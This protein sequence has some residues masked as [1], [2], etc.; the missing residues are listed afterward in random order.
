M[1]TDTTTS[2]TT[3]SAI[4]TTMRLHNRDAGILDPA[5]PASPSS[6]TSVVYSPG[7]SGG[8]S[9]VSVENMGYPTGS[10]ARSRPK[11]PTMEQHGATLSP[12]RLQRPDGSPGGGP[13]GG[14]GDVQEDL[15]RDLN[16][17]GS[18]DFISKYS[19]RKRA[20]GTTSP[21]GSSRAMSPTHPGGERG[22][23]G[24]R[25]IESLRLKLVKVKESQ[26]R[27]ER[28]GRELEKRQTPRRREGVVRGPSFGPLKDQRD[29]SNS[30]ESLSTSSRNSP[31]RD[32][33]HGIPAGGLS[34]GDSLASSRVQTTTSVPM[35]PS[36]VADQ[37]HQRAWSEPNFHS[38]RPTDDE[39]DDDSE[40]NI[41][42]IQRKS[43]D[44]VGGGIQEVDNNNKAQSMSMSNSQTHHGVTSTAQPSS[45]KT[46]T[47]CTPTSSPEGDS[48]EESTLS[49]TQ[50]KNSSSSTLKD[51]FE[52]EEDLSPRCQMSSAQ[53]FEK[54]LEEM[55]LLGSSHKRRPPAISTK[56]SDV[57]HQH[58]IRTVSDPANTNVTN[59]GFTTHPLTPKSKR[60]E[61]CHLTSPDETREQSHRK[62]TDLLAQLHSETSRSLPG[63]GVERKEGRRRVK[64][65][66]GVEGEEDEGVGHEESDSEERPGQTHIPTTM[67]SMSLAEAPLGRGTDDSDDSSGCGGVGRGGRAGNG[68][69]PVGV[70]SGKLANGRYQTHPTGTERTTGRDLSFRSMDSNGLPSLH[71]ASSSSSETA[72]PAPE[73]P[74]SQVSSGSVDSHIG[75]AEDAMGSTAEMSTYPDVV[76][77][78]MAEG[79]DVSDKFERRNGKSLKQK[80]K[81]DPSGDKRKVLQ[82]SQD[83][84]STIEGSHAQSASE[85]DRCEQRESLRSTPSKLCSKQL[86]D[87]KSKSEQLLCTRGR[88]TGA[89]LSKPDWSRPFLFKKSPNK[90]DSSGNKIHSQHSS[91]D[92]PTRR[93]SSTDS[94][95]LTDSQTESNTA[96]SSPQTQSPTSTLDRL[97]VGR[98]LDRSVSSASALAGGRGSV[99]QRPRDLGGRPKTRP[100]IQDVFLGGVYRPPS[101]A[102]L[103]PPRGR[104]GG[105]GS[106]IH[107]NSGST[108]SLMETPASEKVSYPFFSHDL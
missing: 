107:P 26:D 38:S 41:R 31:A 36:V 56:S 50:S 10:M 27:A 51:N 102:D 34:P 85:L 2:T 14:A 86:E 108:L 17:L 6:S 54:D 35:T 96:P 69:Q 89:N 76:L 94:P 13:V 71:D 46:L 29:S 15:E 23:G 74:S 60:P 48:P 16:T 83:L 5:S 49:E 81:S 70:A 68:S 47:F 9:S 37:H 40:V 80:S 21:A 64:G 99:V 72:V 28:A 101:G 67:I 97:R 79:N 24:I 7:V 65:Y 42:Y 88:R 66:E 33:T 32:T 95:M 77:H 12:E 90:D 59:S 106:L 84:M 19:R 93:A 91:E 63:C 44:T 8:Y 25:R 103:S 87:A 58:V 39:D 62:E 11:L 18:T 104:G 52:S 45:K 82:E 53:P 73:E 20:S 1:S 78:V 61:V 55:Q 57:R 75:S 43:G 4:T 30:A 3:P 92:S 98:V 100:P 105:G 22:P